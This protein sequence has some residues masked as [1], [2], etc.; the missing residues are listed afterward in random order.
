MI[1][2]SIRACSTLIAMLVAAALAGCASNH[3]TGRPDANT[4]PWPCPPEW[5]PYAH[6]GCGPAVLLCIPGG[7]AAPGACDQVDLTRSHAVAD[8]A[9]AGAS[10]YRDPSGEIA[11]AW[12][13]GDFAPD[14]GLGTCPAGWTRSADGVCDPALSTTCLTGAEATPGGGCTPTAASDCPSTPFA[15]AGV[16]AVGATIVHVLAGAD[17]ATANGSE[18]HPYPRIADGLAH[19]GAGG[20]VLVGTGTYPEA[21][22]STASVHVLGQCAAHVTLAAPAGSS[23]ASANGSTAAL[24]IRGVTIAGLAD[25]VLVAGGATMRLSKVRVDGA[26]AFAVRVSGSGSR[27]EGDG[28]VISNP[29]PA[30]TGSNGYGVV[31]D[32]GGVAHI[33]HAAILGARVFG[34]GAIGAGA[35]VTLDDVRVRDTHAANDGEVHAALYLQM[36]GSVTAN[37]VVLEHNGIA[38]VT[39]EDPGSVATL[40]DV[41]VRDSVPLADGSWGRGFHAQGGARVV[42]SNFLLD[43]NHD[44]GVSALG[45]GT[46]IAL[47]S[48]TVRATGPGRA[49]LAGRALDA[50]DGATLDASSVRAEDSHEIGVA[51]TGGGSRITLT[52]SVVHHTLPLA[53][54]TNGIGIA[55]AGAGAVIATRVLVDGSHDMGALATG[56]GSIVSFDSCVVRDTSGRADG[57][58]GLGVSVES[59]GRLETT[60]TLIAG[61]HEAGVLVVGAG[62]TVSLRDSAVRDITG[63]AGMILGRGIDARHGASVAAMRVLVERALEIGVAGANTGTTLSLADVIV[64]T[65]TPGARGLGIGAMS[66]GG[67]VFDVQRLAVADARGAALSAVPVTSSGMVIAGS[68]FGGADLFIRRVASGTVRYDNSGPAGM[69]VAVGL[70]ISSQCSMDLTRAVI[71]ESD[72]GF[73]V[74]AGTLAIHQG[75]IAGQRQSPGAVSSATSQNGVTLERMIYTL[76]AHDPLSL[77]TD[78]L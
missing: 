70:D 74:Y 39:A 38:G 53:D 6:G 51:A 49:G 78:L 34:A 9:G 17:A 47:N 71:D 31:A 58:L 1:R 77:N 59:S 25:G 20:W 12:P 66:L 45:A 76:N 13:A 10:Y 65:V 30:G 29:V 73:Y 35:S 11:G 15:D 33:S 36:A 52:D 57:S 26:N 42:A 63:G 40:R 28:I 50:Q 23:A 44:V 46:S 60:R 19:A 54:G 62:A 64:H 37:R 3:N 72:Y 16:E 48:G 4:D 24:D 5:V 7:N 32:T 61:G 27:V 56:A 43:G 22:A 21:I 68:S 18:A 2:H 41:V 55:A 75:A 14:A 8:D 69:P 67:A